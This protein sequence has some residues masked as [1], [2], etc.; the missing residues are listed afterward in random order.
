M[1]KRGGER[2]EAIKSEKLAGSP[3]QSREAAMMATR[4]LVAIIVKDAV[5]GAQAG[6]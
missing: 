3:R 4:S 5:I 2:R 6:H 1:H